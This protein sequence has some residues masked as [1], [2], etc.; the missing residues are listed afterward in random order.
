ML[1]KLLM[2]AAGA[3]MIAFGVAETSYAVTL[4]VVATG[5]DSPRGLTFG[6]DGSL[7]VTEAGR[8]GTGGCI[9]APGAGT[10]GVVM[11][12]GATGAVTRIQ[13]GQQER[14]ITGLPSLATP[15]P[16]TSFTYNAFGPQDIQF[17]S[18]GKAYAV[19]GL[20]S[21]PEQRDNVL[22]IPEFGQLIAIN[23]LNSVSPWTKLADLAAYEGLYNPDSTGSSLYNPYQN[24]IDSNPYAFLIQGNTAYIVDAAGNDL[25]KVKTD[26]SGLEL[27]TI[28]PERPVTDPDTGETIGMQSVPTSI[29]TG[30]DGALYVGELT[31][32]PNPDGAARI[33][34]V[35]ADNQPVIYADGFSQIVDFTF[36]D[37]GGLYILEFASTSLVS[38]DTIPY[39]ALIY[40]A[41]DGT[42][43][44]IASEGL[45]YP[46]ALALASNGDI[47]ISNRGYVSGQGQVVQ[48][49]V[50]E[51][52][53]GASIL[54]FGIFIIVVRSS[55]KQ[56]LSSPIKNYIE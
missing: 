27:V 39:G 44:T 35:G 18:T 9:P 41:P 33:F 56:K 23:Q 42:R 49:A 26:G 53:S 21:S 17:D 37:Q 2:A 20:G 25:F 7:Y 36:D 32:Y 51:P 10:D 12:Y 55:R 30:P 13:N 11:C 47:Y 40:V 14:V 28:F 45:L 52:S 38:P 8:G 5:L 31:G 24:G 22:K 16:N 3:V 29:A 15:I 19:I 6:P 1:K 50:P 46:T 4:N 48:I 54:A 43:K 34:R